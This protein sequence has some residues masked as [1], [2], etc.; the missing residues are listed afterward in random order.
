MTV[1]LL[2]AN[3]GPP[4]RGDFNVWTL[5]VEE[6]TGATIENLTVMVDPTMPAHGHGTTPLPTV[7]P[8]EGTRDQFDVR[9]L[10]LFMPGLWQIRVHVG[11][12]I[13]GNEVNES[14]DFEFWIES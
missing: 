9:P 1:R 14:V 8:I 13:G 4:E 6:T 3:P 10:N 11:A 7:T 2:E 12:T 5:Q